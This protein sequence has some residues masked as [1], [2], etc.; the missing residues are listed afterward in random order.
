MQAFFFPGSGQ[1]L[2][3]SILFFFTFFFRGFFSGFLLYSLLWFLWGLFDLTLGLG[4]QA[5]GSASFLFD[6]TFFSSCMIT[7]S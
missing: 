6:L 4:A 5:G 7:A 2:I 1:R 3:F